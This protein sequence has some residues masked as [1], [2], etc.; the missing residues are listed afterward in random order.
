MSGGEAQRLGLARAWAATRLLVLDDATSS[1]DMITESQIPL[2]GEDSRTRLIFTHR[3]ALAGMAD[4]VV[5]LD[6]GRVRAYG[7]HDL[8]WTDPEYRA[9]F[10]EA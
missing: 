7:S 8:L 9:V 1:L 5:W 3:V 4:A 6:Q 2:F 10:S